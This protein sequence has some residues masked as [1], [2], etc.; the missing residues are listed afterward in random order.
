[1]EDIAER[2]G[3]YCNLLEDAKEERDWDLVQEVID[4]LDELYEEL[5]KSEFDEFD[6]D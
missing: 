1:M 3:Q 5:D 4:M 2:I 6:I